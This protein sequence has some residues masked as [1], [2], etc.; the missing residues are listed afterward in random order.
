MSAQVYLY[1]K[2]AQCNVH[3]KEVMRWSTRDVN[4]V[5]KIATWEKLGKQPSYYKHDDIPVYRE[6]FLVKWLG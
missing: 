2:S 3:H 4:I 6:K 5:T 1:R